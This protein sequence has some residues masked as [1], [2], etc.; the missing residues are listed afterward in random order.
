MKLARVNPSECMAIFPLSPRA[1]RIAS[2]PIPAL[3]LTLAAWATAVEAT[4]RDIDRVA[5]GGLTD[6][7]RAAKLLAT[8]E[9]TR[10]RCEQADPLAPN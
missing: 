2:G 3:Q 4:L 7:A 9:V 6:P 1:P 8:V 10:R 5:R